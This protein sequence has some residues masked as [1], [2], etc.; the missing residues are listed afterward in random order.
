[1]TASGKQDQLRLGFLTAIHLPERGYVGGL[2]VTNHFGRPL[3]FQCTTP[4]LPNRTQEILYG[5]TLLPFVLGEL[6]GSTLVGKV[7][8]KP[9]VIL[10]EQE[11]ILE[12]RNH[13]SIPVICLAEENEEDTARRA[14]DVNPPINAAHGQGVDERAPADE[15]ESDVSTELRMGR[16]RIRFHPAHSSSDRSTVQQQAEQI[17]RDANLGEP[18]DRVREA[19]SETTRSM[20][21]K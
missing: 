7:G 16:Q 1:M 15:K 14:G 19:L 3:E 10:T 18:L 4:V 11:A 17:P 21:V 20:V 2:L 8:I 12:L 13:V 5:P 6:I 9:D